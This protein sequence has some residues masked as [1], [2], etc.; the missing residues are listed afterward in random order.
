MAGPHPPPTQT[1]APPQ[2]PPA[3]PAIATLIVALIPGSASPP[4]RPE[5]TRS[6]ITPAARHTTPPGTTPTSRPASTPGT[7]SAVRQ[8]R[9]AQ[10][11]TGDCLTGSNL[12]LGTSNPWP[13]L[14]T[15]VPCSRPHLAEVFFADHAYWPAPYPGDTAITQRADAKCS[16]VY[17]AYVG[18]PDTHSMYTWDN[19]FPNATDWSRGERELVCVAF[20]PAPGAPGGTP[21]SGSIKGSRR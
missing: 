14:S 7:T 18:V 15:A 19:I 4:T 12:G 1:A 17:T 9:L 5:G 8:L 13:D 11:R 16:A 21:I 2:A 10:L 6:S 3:G 20:H